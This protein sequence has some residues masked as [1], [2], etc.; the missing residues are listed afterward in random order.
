MK[1]SSCL[2]AVFMASV[3]LAETHY[4]NWTAAWSNL[5]IDGVKE[6]PVITC[7]GEFPWPQIRIKKGD[8]VVI[9]LHNDLGDQNTSIHF[10]GL[11]QHNQTSQDGVPMLTQCETPPGYSYTYNFTVDDQVGSYWYHSHSKGQYMDGMRGT[12]IIDD[13]DGFPYDYDEEVV[14]TVSEWYHDLVVPLTS[15]FL[16]RYNPTGAEPIPQNLLWNDTMNG[17]WAVE[18]GK[19]YLLRIINIGGFVSQ[20]LWMEDHEFEVVAVD[21]IYV[22]RNITDYL[23]ITVAQRYDVLVHTKNDTST[24]Y[25]FM[26][27]FDLDMLDT[28]PDDLIVNA[29]SFIVYDE[30]ADMPGA[31]ILGDAEPLD[32]FYLVPLEAEETLP[33]PDHV[34]TVDV[35]MDNLG[36]GVNYAFFNRTS[37]T[38]PKVPAL[39]T[40]F[41]AGDA[42]TNETVYGTNTGSIVLEKDE[43]VEIV[44]N[45]NDTGKHPFHL[46][47]HVFQVIERGPDF[48]DSAEP[49]PYSA[50]GTDGYEEPEYPA[51]RDTLYVRPQ[52]YFRIR[53]KA[54]NPG[55][56]FF[57]CHIEWHLLQGLAIVMIEDPKGIQEF[58]TLD[59]AWYANCDAMGVQ[60]DGNAA[61]NTENYYDLTGQNVQEKELPAGFTARGI[62]AMVFSCVAGVLGCIVIFIY[63][64]ADVPNIEQRVLEDLHMESKDLL[65]DDDEDELDRL[66]PAAEADSDKVDNVQENTSSQG[67]SSDPKLRH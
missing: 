6:R 46:H 50:N 34:I 63:G 26:Q 2:S 67:S 35:V 7:N 8:R 3:A 19:T 33:E 22:E 65:N 57:H 31:Y 66:D 56:W 39:G 9:E 25:A 53:F 38:T 27:A 43:I 32:D 64:M 29:T 13:P 14:L 18:P 59:D 28:Q 10:H 37:Y 24:N 15:S 20:Y 11:F 62:V 16:D 4:Y 60:S 58:Q 30:S 54:D 36:N 41:S 55:V 21:G 61:G 51:R 52:S 12:F 17:T 42:A 44:L 45:N 40:V 23:Y 49:V 5:N 48:T 1:L 47:G